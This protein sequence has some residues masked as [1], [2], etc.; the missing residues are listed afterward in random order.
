MVEIT[1]TCPK[2]QEAA[3]KGSYTQKL[4]LGER[5]VLFVLKGAIYV[6]YD[7]V[8]SVTLLGLAQTTYHKI[9]GRTMTSR[10]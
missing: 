3:V 7:L 1:F 8:I 10:I 2:R 5:I 4:K 6:Y 9:V